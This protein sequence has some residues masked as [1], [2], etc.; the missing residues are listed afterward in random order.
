MVIQTKI[1]YQQKKITGAMS[2]QVEPVLV[3]MKAKDWV[4]LYV[5]FIIKNTIF[6]QIV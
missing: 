3:M 6:I 4:K 2:Q 5:I 1:I